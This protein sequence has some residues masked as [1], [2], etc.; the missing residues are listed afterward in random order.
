MLNVVRNPKPGDA[1]VKD[2]AER[3]R[4]LSQKMKAQ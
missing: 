3:L 4:A 2:V 1:P